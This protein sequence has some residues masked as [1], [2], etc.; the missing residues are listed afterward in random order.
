MSL[1]DFQS[2]MLPLLAFAGDGNPHTLGEAR[3]TIA[4]RLGLDEAAL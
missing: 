4:A 1:P 2:L 3:T